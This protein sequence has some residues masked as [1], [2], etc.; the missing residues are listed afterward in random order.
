MECLYL[1]TMNLQSEKPYLHACKG[2]GEKKLEKCSSS[3]KFL[4]TLNNLLM[5][6]CFNIFV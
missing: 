1:E 6:F 4:D 5:D 3:I 2:E